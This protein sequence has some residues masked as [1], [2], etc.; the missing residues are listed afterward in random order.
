[1]DEGWPD[2]STA[3]VECLRI[4]QSRRNEHETT[5]HC[6]HR[7]ARDILLGRDGQT[8]S[9]WSTSGVWSG[10]RACVAERKCSC[11]VLLASDIRVCIGK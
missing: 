9:M 1:M 6:W 10:S 7:Q 2:V 5:L 11:A 3:E 8:G 4:G